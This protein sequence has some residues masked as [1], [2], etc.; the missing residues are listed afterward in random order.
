MDKEV[1]TLTAENSTDTLV[2]PW[3]DEAALRRPALTAGAGRVTT[4]TIPRDRSFH[5]ANLSPPPQ[6]GVRLRGSVNVHPALNLHA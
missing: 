6:D 3:Y 5:R 2:P 4:N 1:F